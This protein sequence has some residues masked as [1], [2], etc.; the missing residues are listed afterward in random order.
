MKK[1]IKYLKKY[2]RNKPLAIISSNF[3]VAFQ[4]QVSSK[5]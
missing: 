1:F 2:Y 4:L 3:G 5:Y